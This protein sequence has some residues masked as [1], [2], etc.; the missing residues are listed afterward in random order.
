MKKK[1]L[2]FKKAWLPLLAMI[3]LELL[4]LSIIIGCEIIISNPVEYNAMETLIEI[5]DI[6]I[7]YLDMCVILE[8]SAILFVLFSLIKS[9][10]SILFNIIN[11]CIEDKKWYQKRI[12][13]I[14]SLK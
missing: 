5:E 4:V 10:W 1:K 14:N 6:K 8:L 13:Y 12:R 3:L 11:K 9:I 7:R 2:N